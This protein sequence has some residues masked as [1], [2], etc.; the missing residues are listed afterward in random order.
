MPYLH[1]TLSQPLP[2]ARRAEL[3]QSLTDL[4][5]RLLAKRR[6]V[7]A[8]SVCQ[9]DTQAWFVGAQPLVGPSYHLDVQITAG[10][11]DASQKAGYIAAVHALMDHTLG[12]VHPASYVALIEIAADAWGYAGHTQAARRADRR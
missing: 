6:E 10:S 5:E 1:L 9:Q 7:T 8:L 12:E 11:N 4:T 3:A 2:V